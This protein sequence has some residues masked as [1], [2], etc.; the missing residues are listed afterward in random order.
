MDK[1]K[2]STLFSGLEADQLALVTA[3]AKNIYL[4]EGQNLF[5]QQQLAEHFYFLVSG[6]IKLY[7]LS[8]EGTEKVI[9][10][11]RA[12]QTFAEA[13][14]FMKAKK[15]PVNAQAISECHLIRI[16]MKSFTELLDNSPE[17][18]IKI[19]AHMSQRLHGLIQEVEQLTALNAKMRVIQF[20][21]R[22]VPIDTASPYQ[23]EAAIPKTVFAS[24]VSIRPETLSRVLQQLNEEK[25]ICMDK[26]HIVLLDINQLRNY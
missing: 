1:L 8:V 5:A 22:D 19:L 20:L 26:K 25:L 2:Q 10:L 3:N 7:R 16:E 23:L 13:V 15:Y 9:E 24:R 18:S 4:S 6:H 11:I 12:G 14:M 21:L 17:T